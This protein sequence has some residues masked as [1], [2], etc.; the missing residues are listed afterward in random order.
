MYSSFCFLRLIVLS[1]SFSYFS[2]LLQ[3]I[4]EKNKAYINDMIVAVKSPKQGVTMGEYTVS[5]LIF[6]KDFV[7][8]S[9]TPE[10]LQKHIEKALEYT[11]KWRV[12]ANVKT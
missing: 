7:G 8:I 5:G 3:I 9:E 2:P 1:R 11:R 12:T 10:G 4:L 6:A